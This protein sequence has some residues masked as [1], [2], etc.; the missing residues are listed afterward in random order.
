MNMVMVYWILK[1]HWKKLEEIDIL[2]DYR[3][4]PNTIKLLM[5]VKELLT[6][7][8]FKNI[9]INMAALCRIQLWI[10]PRNKI[11]LYILCQY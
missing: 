8:I 6:L 2:Y 11:F 7:F 10:A 9:I 5:C 4:G 1:L 3:I